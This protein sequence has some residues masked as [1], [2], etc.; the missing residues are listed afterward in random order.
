MNS[1]KKQQKETKPM[2][3]KN[4]GKKEGISEFLFLTQ[5][6]YRK[7]IYPIHFQTQVPSCYRFAAHYFQ[8]LAA[9]NPA[10]LFQVFPH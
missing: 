6:K 7:E 5:A 9:Q 4:V 10:W 1:V 8:E 2:A 3:E